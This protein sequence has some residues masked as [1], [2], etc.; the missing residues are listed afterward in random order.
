MSRPAHIAAAFN[1]EPFF[2][3]IDE[4]SEVARGIIRVL[5]RHLRARVRDLN[6]L[7]ARLELLERVPAPSVA[8]EVIAA[9]EVTPPAHSS[10]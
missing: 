6:E 5:T 2:E 10:E 4:R 8:P 1:V 7:R 9:L 3:L